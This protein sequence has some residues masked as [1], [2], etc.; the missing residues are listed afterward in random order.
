MKSG[1][2]GW[3]VAD[4]FTDLPVLKGPLFLLPQGPLPSYLDL[5]FLYSTYY[6]PTYYILTCLVPV[7][8]TRR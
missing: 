7:P 1:N 8:P 5:I 6:H 4:S 3:P 2:L